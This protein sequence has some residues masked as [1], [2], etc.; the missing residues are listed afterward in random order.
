MAPLSDV[1]IDPELPEPTTPSVTEAVVADQV[2][3]HVTEP[4]GHHAP[5]HTHCQNCGAELRGAFCHQCGQHDF[6]FHRSFGHVF[7]E[8]L[9]SF[10]HFDEKFFRTIITL[11]FEPG[12]LSAEFNAGK[13]ASQ[14]PPFRLYLF[15]SV[16]FFFIAFLGGDHSRG[17]PVI[18]DQPA[19]SEAAK[20]AG[21]EIAKATTKAREQLDHALAVA[22]TPEE[23]ENLRTIRDLA[24]KFAETDAE[25]TAV[26]AVSNPVVAPA[27]GVPAV[28]VPAES[29]S[30]AKPAS[31]PEQPKVH[32]SGRKMP[33]KLKD[34]EGEGLDGAFSRYV[35]ERGK[36][37]YEHR[38][39]LQESVIHAVPKLL[40]FCLPLFALFTRVLFRRTG[41]VY[42]QHLIVALHFHTFV[43]L[44]WLVA[45]GWEKIA[46]LASPGVGNFL[47]FGA[48]L[49][50][51][52]Y[53]V[54]MLRRLFTQ[55]W[56]RTILKTMLLGSLYLLTLALGFVLVAFIMFL[57]L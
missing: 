1:S 9:E 15:V 50:L 10:L 22:R 23:R 57:M 49:W 8:T 7:F 24:A 33:G 48:S 31:P 32:P 12:R 27:S 36:Y 21:K 4:H 29:P 13:R 41:Y 19:D 11:L 38:K 16:L 46:A 45:T 28:N 14:M 3:A 18:L 53:P 55:S 17:D 56:R 5:S 6:D 30:A 26:A 51:V 37:A 34:N 54:L 43:Y 35:A 39:E 25:S 40:L 20:E 52:A 2:V 47:N 42:L 44:W